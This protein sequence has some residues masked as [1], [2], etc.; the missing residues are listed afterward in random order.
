MFPT[1]D[2]AL[3][4]QEIFNQ[5]CITC[6]AVSTGNEKPVEARTAPNLATF[7]ERETI[8]GVLEHNEEEL[9]RW[10]KEPDVIK[11][12]NKMTG[13]YPELKPDELDALA[14]YLM[15]LKVENK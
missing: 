7:G 10:L 13:T 15:E 12:G 11:P 6:H 9:K 8:A 1:T 2:L 3:Q 14:A 5:S 4:G